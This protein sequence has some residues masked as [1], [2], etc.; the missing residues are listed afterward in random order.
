MGS[1]S[2]RY[3]SRH[4]FSIHQVKIS[5]ISIMN[6][7][8]KCTQLMKAYVDKLISQYQEVWSV[9]EMMF[10]VKGTAPI[11]KG[12]YNW[13]WSI[14]DPQTKFF[15]AIEISKQRK[16]QYAKIIFYVGK[17]RVQSSPSYII[18]DA[19]LAY[20]SALKNEFDSRRTAHIS[21]VCVRRIC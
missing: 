14:I 11:G 8:R 21:K 7:V 20:K 17:R 2:Y 12:Y 3:I 10:D 5:H 9:D 19:L 18:T 6:W 15:I 13:I 1:I 16:T 4:V